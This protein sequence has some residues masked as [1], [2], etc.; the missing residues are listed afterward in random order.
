MLQDLSTDRQTSFLR[1][2]PTGSRLVRGVA[3]VLLALFSVGTLKAD[4]LILD[5]SLSGFQTVGDFD[6]SSCATPVAMDQS[7][8]LNED[9]EITTGQLY[10]F[11][12]KQ[13]INSVNEIVL[14]LDVDPNM[15]PADY[16]LDSMEFS[17]ED[18]KYTLGGNSL[19]LPAYES[20]AMKPEAQ[21]AIKLNYD[22]MQKFNEFSTEKIKF[23][24]VDGKQEKVPLK[25]G[26]TP[27]HASTFSAT[28]MILL[29]AF[30]GF[31][32]FVFM[33]LFRTT[34][35]SSK[36]AKARSATYPA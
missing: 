19:R 5:E 22:F 27:Q 23:S 14:S 35:K 21:I 13:G 24:A 3:F 30:A 1:P 33:V 6:V 16:D 12:K 17:I 25:V 18:L 32:V 10:A 31:W 34:A 28:R 11:Y 26:V 4:E 9:G 2:S 7:G 15:V 8:L 29:T 36:P 20:S